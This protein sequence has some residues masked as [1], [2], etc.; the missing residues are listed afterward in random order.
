MP[1]R[2]LVST[3]VV[4]AVLVL[5]GCRQPPPR[6]NAPTPRVVSFSPAISG[7]L[8]AMGLGRHVVGVTRFCTRPSGQDDIPVVGDR[9][10]VSAE[11]ILATKPDIVLIQQN[12]DD[13]A[14]VTNIV[15]QIRIEHFTIETF[16]DV[17]AAMKTIGK[18]LGNEP[19]G[20]AASDAFGARL[21]AV[22]RKTAKLPRPKV[23]FVLGYDKP[24]TG[25]AGTFMD[26]MIEA[27]GG[28]DAATS[29]G[30]HG[31]KRLNREN[32]IAMAPDVLIC[33]VSTGQAPAAKAYWKTLGD[34]PAV[35]GGEVYV[36][37]DN[38]W[39]I[40]SAWSAGFAERLAE[41]LH[42]AAMAGGIA[43]G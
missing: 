5:A 3:I 7:M 35:R 41:I 36:V 21:A 34:L 33:Q 38:R 15:P 22:R 37:T 1:R 10:R 39:T 8:F 32:I 4:S 6:P 12:P 17:A 11:A 28:R 42:P 29:A 2:M 24:S 18:L 14:A 27:A 40:P 23:L 25:G 31:W 19:V 30:Y 13:F 9:A 26:E 16:A 20:V 43:G